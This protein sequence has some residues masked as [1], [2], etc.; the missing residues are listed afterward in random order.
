MRNVGR[1]AAQGQVPSSQQDA[2]S[3][4]SLQTTLLCCTTACSHRLH[5]QF[6]NS[7]EK[8]SAIRQ[9]YGQKGIMTTSF[10]GSLS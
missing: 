6:Y 10:T 2:P 1:K 5:F 7:A 8:N 3:H 4:S 9:G